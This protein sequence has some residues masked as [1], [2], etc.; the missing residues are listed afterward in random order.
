MRVDSIY[1]CT[2]NIDFIEFYSSTRTHFLIRV[3]ERRGVNA[4]CYRT[5]GKAEILNLAAPIGT[6]VISSVASLVVTGL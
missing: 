1:S 5:I 4:S 6:S 3:Q 2:E